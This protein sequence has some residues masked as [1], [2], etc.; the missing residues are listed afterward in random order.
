MIRRTGR[1]RELRVSSKVLSMWK[2]CLLFLPPDRQIES[3][4][5]LS[6]L[7]GDEFRSTFML[8]PHS[9]DSPTL[10]VRILHFV[11]KE[12]ASDLL[13]VFLLFLE[14]PHFQIAF[15]VIQSYSLLPSMVW[16]GTNARPINISRKVDPPFQLCERILQA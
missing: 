16:E 6:V 4:L 14:V 8:T 15:V 7:A 2:V 9:C 10:S 1:G 3:P 12:L 13:E 11:W 5:Y